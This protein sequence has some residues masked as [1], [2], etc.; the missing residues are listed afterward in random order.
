[1]NLHRS[2]ESYDNIDLFEVAN[3]PAIGNPPADITSY[4]VQ[5]FLDAARPLLNV[6][7]VHLRPEDVERLTEIAS[8]YCQRFSQKLVEEEGYGVYPPGTTERLV[9]EN[10]MF[11]E[12][13]NHAD[14]DWG[15]KFGRDA[16]ISAFAAQVMASNS[17]NRNQV[18]RILS[19]VISHHALTRF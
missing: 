18:G 8:K 1:M 10:H 13:R 17:A 12:E 19:Q 2:P 3:S 6:E 5:Q 7:S 11:V 9:I 4:E 15:T 16:L 14:D